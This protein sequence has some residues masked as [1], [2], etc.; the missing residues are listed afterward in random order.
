MVAMSC[1]SDFRQKAESLTPCLETTAPRHQVHVN[2][3]TSYQRVIGSH[4]QLYNP[5]P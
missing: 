1:T 5:F 4:V 3:D 2:R